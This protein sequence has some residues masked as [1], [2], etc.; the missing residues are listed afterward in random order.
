MTEIGFNHFSI[1]DWGRGSIN[2]Q[3]TF[4]FAVWLY[5]TFKRSTEPLYLRF[6]TEPELMF[7]TDI[8]ICGGYIST[9]HEIEALMF[10]LYELELGLTPDIVN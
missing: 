7:F 8:S 2:R 10:K 4:N 5:Q 1:R 3:T 6:T 9:V